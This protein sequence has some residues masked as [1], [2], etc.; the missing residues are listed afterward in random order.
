M[1]DARKKRHYFCRVYNIWWSVHTIVWDHHGKG[2]E[3]SLEIVWKLSPA[4][5]ARV[6]GDKHR[7][8]L[9]QLDLTALKHESL[10]L[11][12]DNNNNT[13]WLFMTSGHH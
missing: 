13:L 1:R 11:R 2:S 10:G 5:I 12:E 3:E 8:R 7:T 6:H 4:S 9:V